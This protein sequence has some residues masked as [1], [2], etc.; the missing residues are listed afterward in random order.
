EHL[1]GFAVTAGTVGG[2]P[3]HHGHTI[4]MPVRRNR[5]GPVLSRARSGRSGDVAG[6]VDPYFPHGF[7]TAPKLR[8]RGRTVA[9][10]GVG[11]G[12][13]RDWLHRRREDGFR[14]GLRL[15]FGLGLRPWLGL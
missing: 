1:A 10:F 2:I 9:T 4:R 13:L 5:G 12:G 3:L 11:N 8:S 6:P 7:L 14:F 15:W